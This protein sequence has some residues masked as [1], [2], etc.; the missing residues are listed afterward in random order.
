MREAVV[1]LPGV[2]A[3][4]RMFGPQ[5]ADLSSDR[6]VMV[7]PT[8]LGERVEEI[9]S[10]AL[11]VLPKRFA[12]C[13]HGFGGTIAMEIMRR[14]PERVTR[15]ALMSTQPLA[16]TP[17]EAADLDRLIVKART[18][19]IAAVLDTIRP[20]ACVAEGPYR[21]EIM[22]LIRDMA[23]TL[24]EEAFLRQTRSRQ[25]CRDQQSTLRRITVPVLVMCGALDPLVPVK[26]HQVM[27]E[28]IPGAD[29]CVLDGAAHFPTL[30]A[31]MEACGALRDWLAKP[32]VLR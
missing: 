7:V 15:L 5:I 19:Q 10:S 28:L 23:L 12:L 13:G 4:A 16:T 24:G 6:A 21:A 32:F 17:L 9:A 29:L 3:D 31:P 30:E 11:D 14:A 18:G 26:R 8:T 20:Q 22:E 25:R 27:A 2:M 1:F